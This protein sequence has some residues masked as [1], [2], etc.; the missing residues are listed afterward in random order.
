MKWTLFLFRQ[1]HSPRFSSSRV[2][3]VLILS[4]ESR[5]DSQMGREAAVSMKKQAALPFSGNSFTSNSHAPAWG[6]QQ[7]S[8]VL[9]SL[10]YRSY[11]AYRTVRPFFL[12]Q[13]KEGWELLTRISSFPSLYSRLYLWEPRDA[14]TAVFCRTAGVLAPAA[15]AAG[16]PSMAR[17]R[18]PHKIVFR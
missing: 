4:A 11:S 17:Q 7:P 1:S 9:H 3:S 12:I 5:M 13:F 18:P 6:F 2:L 8:L 14:V 15:L 16:A 10:W